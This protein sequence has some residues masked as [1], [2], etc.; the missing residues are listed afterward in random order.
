MYLF[1]GEF[2]FFKGE[3]VA[4]TSKSYLAYDQ[5][6][7]AEKRSSKG[8]PHRIKL[9]IDQYKQALYHGQEERH[10]VEMR[11]LRLS[12][13]RKMARYTISKKGLSDLL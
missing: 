11:S 10:M 2:A 8:I 13:E 1:L 9:E 12:R 6:K 3:Y 5:D 4:L 7:D